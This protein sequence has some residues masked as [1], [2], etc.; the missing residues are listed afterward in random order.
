MLNLKM[1]YLL[2]NTFHLL[3]TELGQKLSFVQC[4]YFDFDKMQMGP[5]LSHC[6]VPRPPNRIPPPKRRLEGQNA[7]P[8]GAKRIDRMRWHS[9]DH[10][11]TP[12]RAGTPSFPNFS[13]TV[14]YRTMV[15]ME[16]GI[17]A[18][19]ESTALSVCMH[20]APDVNMMSYPVS[21]HLKGN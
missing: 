15:P 9:L 1:G 18:P 8:A 10:P 2:E 20:C 6:R 14:T 3:F 5:F 11:R 12:T 13:H 7:R 16:A 19:G 21:I 17:K 4:R